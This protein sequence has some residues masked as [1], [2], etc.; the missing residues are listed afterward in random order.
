MPL[1]NLPLLRHHIRRCC[2]RNVF[3]IVGEGKGTVPYRACEE[4]CDLW[5]TET[6]LTNLLIDSW[7]VFLLL[8][9][10]EVKVLWLSM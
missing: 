3:R 5:K 7:T 2:G 1:H 8:L 9:R 10:S 6:L 4:L